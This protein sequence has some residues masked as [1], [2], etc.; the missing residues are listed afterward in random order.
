[1]ISNCVILTQYQIQPRK[2]TPFGYKF[3]ILNLFRHF[4]GEI[5]PFRFD[6]RYYEVKKVDDLGMAEIPSPSNI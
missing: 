1:M 5:K 3:Q 6:D 4:L 2:A